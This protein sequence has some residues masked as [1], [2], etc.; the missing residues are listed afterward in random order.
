MSAVCIEPFFELNDTNC[1]FISDDWVL[2]NEAKEI[3]HLL[4]SDVYIP[5][6]GNDY[7]RAGLY[8]Q[9]RQHLSYDK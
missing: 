2:Y 1:Y 6:K 4:D 8:H 9:I 5:P 3:C 7:N